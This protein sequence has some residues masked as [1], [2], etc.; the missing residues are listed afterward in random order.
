MLAE[1]VRSGMF[2]W[3]SDSGAGV[4]ARIRRVIGIS[5]AGSDLH[6]PHHMAERYGA[7]AMRRAGVRADRVVSNTYR[8]TEARLHAR[9]APRATSRIEDPRDSRLSPIPGSCSATSP[10]WWEISEM[11]RLAVDQLVHPFVGEPIDAVVGHGGARLHLR[12]SGRP[13]AE[14]RIRSP[15]KAGKA[16]LRRAVGL[17]RAGVRHGRPWKPTSMPSIPATGSCSSTISSPPAVPHPRAA[18]SSSGSA[19]RSRRAPS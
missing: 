10:R 18:S 16:A 7:A 12:R 6:E 19:E 11:L 1:L 13:G 2:G 3:G 4:G 8:R 9:R 5:T 14:R 17:V 15:A